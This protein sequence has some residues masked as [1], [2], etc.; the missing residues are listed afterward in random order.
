MEKR[1]LNN[2]VA[3]QRCRQRKR[4]YHQS[5]TKVRANEQQL[6]FKLGIL[7]PRI[8]KRLRLG[9]HTQ[10]QFHWHPWKAKLQRNIVDVS[11]KSRKIQHLCSETC[12]KMQR[13]AFQ[14]A[15]QLWCK[16]SV[17]PHLQRCFFNL[18]RKVG[19][20]TYQMSVQFKDTSKELS[21]KT[22]KH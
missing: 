9:A 6:H 5:L 22:F 17:C 16:R 1:R 2:R 8:L 11:I 4:Q 18:G 13:N 10:G 3:A 7:K 12:F 20:S 14:T 15:F 21:W 19:S